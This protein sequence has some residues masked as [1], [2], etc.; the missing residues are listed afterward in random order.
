MT[1]EEVNRICGLM[2]YLDICATDIHTVREALEKQIPK[3]PEEYW[4]GYA[5]GYPVIEYQCPCCGR[6]IDDTD[7]HCVCGQTI[8]WSEEE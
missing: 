1:Y 7:H 2:W 8:D 4:D 6:D 3:K 5:D